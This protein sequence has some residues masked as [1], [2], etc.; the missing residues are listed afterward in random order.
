TTTIIPTI[1]AAAQKVEDVCAF[2]MR[3][4]I[5]RCNRG[6]EVYRSVANSN[7]SKLMCPCPPAYYG[8]FCQYQNQRVSLT[9]QIKVSFE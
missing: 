6:I 3:P 9:V 2:I 8:K 5:W 1:I 4:C 7:H